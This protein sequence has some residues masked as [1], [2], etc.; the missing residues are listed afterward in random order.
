MKWMQNKQDS[1][2]HGASD[3][4]SSSPF[5]HFAGIHIPSNICCSMNTGCCGS[6]IVDTGAS[7]HMTFDHTSLTQSKKP[8]K[9]LFV[10]LPDGATKPV[11]QIGQFNLTPNLTLQK[12]LHVPDFKFNLLSVSQLVTDNNMCVL[13]F[14]NTCV[15]QDLTTKRIVAMAPKHGGL[16]KL[17]PLIVG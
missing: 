2:S 7:D 11:S 5:A 12:V 14:P 9:P 15:I 1:Y 3:A 17:D 6:W 10:T 13:F 4:N 16:Y 8:S